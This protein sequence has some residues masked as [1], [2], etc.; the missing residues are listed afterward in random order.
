MPN[1]AIPRV[2]EIPFFIDDISILFAIRKAAIIPIGSEIRNAKYVEVK[3]DKGTAIETG[4]MIGIIP[5]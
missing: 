4:I 2:G 1:I 5:L 3:K